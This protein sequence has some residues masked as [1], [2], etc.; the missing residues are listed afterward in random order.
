MNLTA[1]IILL[2]LGAVVAWFGQQLLSAS[3]RRGWLLALLPAASFALLLQTTWQLQDSFIVQ[4]IPWIATLDLS[5]SFYFDA[6]A[7][8]F[9]LIVTGIGNL[10][11]CLC[12]LLL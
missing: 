7:A 3:P 11:N 12:G 6:L 2:G 5:L 9:G 4:S 8:L 1:A 10:D